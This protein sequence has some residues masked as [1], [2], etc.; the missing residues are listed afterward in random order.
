MST[1]VALFVGKVGQQGVNTL[2]LP[3]DAVDIGLPLLPEV[4]NLPEQSSRSE[5]VLQITV[6]NGAGVAGQFRLF[7]L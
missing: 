3:A 6:E 7:G 2:G 5:T 4:H 1:A